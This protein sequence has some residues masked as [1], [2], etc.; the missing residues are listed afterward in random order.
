MQ[1]VAGAEM[2]VPTLYV[3]Q[4]LQVITATKVNTSHLLM[5]NSFLTV[6]PQMQFYKNYIEMQLHIF[7]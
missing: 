6:R 2:Y 7:C 4:K 5:F 1:L 3:R